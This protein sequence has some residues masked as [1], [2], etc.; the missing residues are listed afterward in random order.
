MMTIA[1]SSSTAR[2]YTANISKGSALVP[3]MVALLREWEPHLSEDEFYAR[4]V[5]SNI[6]GKATRS[7]LRDILSRVFAPRFLAPGCPSVTAMKALVE[8]ATP[9]LKAGAD[10]LARPSGR[11]AGEVRRIEGVRLT[12]GEALRCS[13]IVLCTGTSLNG[14]CISGERTF[15][16]GRAGE[17]AATALSDALRSL[18]FE[19]GRLK[20]GTPPRLDRNTIDWSLAEV[21]PGSPTPLFFSD[22]ARRAFAALPE[23]PVPWR[24]QVPCHLVHTTP[25]THEVI[26]ANLHRAP[27]FNGLIEGIGPRYCP[28]IEDKIVR[29]AEKESHQLFLEPEGLRTREIY[30][31]GANTSLPEEVQLA[32]LRAIPALRHCEIVRAGYA[33]EYDF[34]PTYQTLTSLASK[35]VEGLYL[36]GQING[37]SGYEEAAAQGIIAGLNAARYTQ[38]LQP[39]VLRRDQAYIGVLIDDLMTKDH[40]EPYRMHTSRAEHRLLLRQDNAELRL[41]ALAYAVGLVDAERQAQV[42]ARRAAIAQALETL[43][44]VRLS[45]VE[46]RPFGR[47]ISGEEALR[48]HDVTFAQVAA[49]APQ[50]AGLAE[51]PDDVASEVEL[52]VRYAGYIAREHAAV[53][54]AV[55]ME[56]Y[57]LAADLAYGTVRGLR[58]EAREK[59]TR[60]R[61]LTVGQAA[62]L[63]GITPADVAAL[64]VH[65]HAAPVLGAVRA[66]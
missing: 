38:D 25:Q 42:E 48:R 47:P 13:A 52:E 36:A 56:G 15:A 6:L 20:T 51:L 28:S 65:A 32:M 29:F 58:R 60:F 9:S 21:Q 14:R 66:P 41:T 18:G 46:G 12:T 45:G 22:T 35:R 53:E 27:M 23:E 54:R 62:R 50:E 63:A 43:R 55:R 11:V 7:R 24:A 4:V 34:A 44:A 59:L 16:A 10:H 3:E 19:L 33:V 30:V 31:Q 26:R 64:L 49:A 39:V 17:P 61:P 2:H 1:E 5:E 57:A 40:R 37:T 8:G